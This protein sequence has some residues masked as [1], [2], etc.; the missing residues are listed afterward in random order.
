MFVLECEVDC[1]REREIE[2]DRTYRIL[3]LR[4]VDSTK[5]R[6]MKKDIIRSFRIC[7][8][9]L[10]TKDQINPVMKMLRHELTLQCFT[11]NSNELLR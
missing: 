3:D 6:E 7:T 4:H 8:S 1:M 5:V 10:V 9:L 11:V 2:R